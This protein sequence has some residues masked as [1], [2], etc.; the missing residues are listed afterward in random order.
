[1]RKS[2]HDITDK[3]KVNHCVICGDTEKDGKLILA[4]TDRGQD[5]FC[6]FCYNAQ[7][8]L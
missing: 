5:R 6:E 4:D 2:I 3:I 1:M 7:Q 8:N